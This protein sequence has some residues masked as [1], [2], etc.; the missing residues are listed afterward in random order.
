MFRLT[1]VVLATTLCLP[2]AEVT[3]PDI[4]TIALVIPTGALVRIKTTSKQTIQG[5]LTNTTSEGV[6]LQVVEKDQITER[7]VP[8][9]DM[10]SIKQTNKPIGV[11][12][13][14]LIA[15]GMIY[16][17]AFLIGLAFGY[18]N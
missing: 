8:F 2:A 1:A 11:G 13:T 15:L 10:K 6:T 3:K 7:T 5:K 17:I 16:G 18:N 9:A 4:R 12:K 14:V